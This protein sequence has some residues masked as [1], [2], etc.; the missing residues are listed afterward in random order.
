MTQDHTVPQMYLKRFAVERSNGHWQLITQRKPDTKRIPLKVSRVSSVQNFYWGLGPTG[1]VGHQMEEFLYGLEDAATPVFSAMLDTKDKKPSAWPLSRGDKRV[2]AE[3]IAAQVLRT[4]RQRKRLA[5][6]DFGKS[7]S[8]AVLKDQNVTDFHL[9]YMRRNIPLLTSEILARPWGFGFSATGLIT[10][11]SP[12]VMLNGHDDDNQVNSFANCTVVLPLDSKRLLILPSEK[13]RRRDPKKRNDHLFKLSEGAGWGMNQALYGAAERTV[14]YHPELEFDSA[15]LVQGFDIST[16][17]GVSEKASAPHFD[18]DYRVM[19]KHED[20]NGFAKGENIGI[21]FSEDG[22]T[23]HVPSSDL[24]VVNDLI[25]Y[26]LQLLSNR[27]SARGDVETW[28][29]IQALGRGGK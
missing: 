13:L 18:L 16:L 1:A 11:D 22:A 6:L 25:Q 4:M 9:Q 7:K 17:W 12:V 26:N 19:K 5:Y 29:K 20:I 27:A 24:P 10:G 15:S 2:V 21:Q 23:I 28:A 14:Y 8:E 3:W